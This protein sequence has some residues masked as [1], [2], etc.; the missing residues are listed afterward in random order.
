MLGISAIAF[1][2]VI[3]YP[4]VGAQATLSIYLEKLLIIAIGGPTTCALSQ[5]VF[6]LGM[7]LA[8]ADYSRIF[9]R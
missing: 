7:Y 1:R 9:L 2:Y 6:L 3:G 8:G 5:V 4:A